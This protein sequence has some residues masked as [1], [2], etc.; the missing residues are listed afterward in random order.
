M[1]KFTLNLGDYA[2][3]TS[4]KLDTLVRAVVIE[5][6]ARVVMRSPVGDAT[7]WKSPPPPGYVGGRARGSWQYGFNAVPDADLSTIDPSGRASIDRIKPSLA[8]GMHYIVN[9]LPYAQRLEDGWSTQAPAGIIGLVAVEFGS[10]I[11]QTAG[12]LK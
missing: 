3:R 7:L 1:S 4:E 2:K 10:I 6:G 5:V 11:S 9:A 12:G 8:A